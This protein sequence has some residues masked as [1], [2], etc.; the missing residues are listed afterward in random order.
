MFFI[1][2]NILEQYLQSSYFVEHPL[3]N[4]SANKR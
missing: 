1:D 4:A 2:E 3:P